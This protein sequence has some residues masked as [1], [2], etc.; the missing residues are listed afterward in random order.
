M[1]HTLSFLL[2][3]PFHPFFYFTFFSSIFDIPLPSLYLVIFPLSARYTFP[4]T[5]KTTQ[6]LLTLPLLSS[7]HLHTPFSFQR[8]LF[9]SFLLSCHLYSDTPFSTPYSFNPLFTLHIISISKH[10]F[11]PSSHSS[12]VLHTPFSFRAFLPCHFLTPSFLQHTSSYLSQPPSYLAN[13]SP[14]VY[15][16]LSTVPYSLLSPLP[17]RPSLLIRP[18]STAAAPP[19]KPGIV[20]AQFSLELLTPPDF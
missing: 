18:E 5:F 1:L 3:I 19:F 11:Q 13:S 6:L 20:G 16:Y 17:S 7:A 4:A 8:A 14:T 10:H 2:H 9:Q 12:G 15:T